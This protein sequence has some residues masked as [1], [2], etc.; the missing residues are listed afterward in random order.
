MI[1]SALLVLIFPENIIAVNWL[2]T[3]MK[4]GIVEKKNFLM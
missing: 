4:N 2:F 3:C 1:F